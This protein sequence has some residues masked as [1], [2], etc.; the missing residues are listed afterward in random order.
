LRYSG[1]VFLTLLGLYILIGE[2]FS[3]HY[4]NLI[5]S[6][7]PVLSAKATDSLYLITIQDIRINIFTQ[8]VTVSGLR[9]QVDLDVLQRRRAEGRPPHVILD[10]SV[11][12]ANVSGVKWDDLSAEKTLSCRAVTFHQ[13]EIR[14]QIMPEWE[15]AKKSVVHRSPSISRVSAQK[16]TIDG[17]QLDVRYSYGDTGFSVQTRGGMIRASD[18]NYYPRHAFDPDR[19]FGAVAAEI[20]LTGATYSYP[21]SLYEYGMNSIAFNSITKEG[22]ISGLRIHPVLSHDAFYARVGFRKDV[23]ECFLPKVLVHDL[24]WRTLLT[25]HEFYAGD[26]TFVSPDFAIFYSKKPPV[27]PSRAQALYPSQILKH[28][29]LP[30]TV[31]L[32]NISDAAVRYSESN[33]KTGAT[34]TLEFDYMNGTILNVSNRD[35]EIA[36]SPVCRMLFNGKFM[37]RTSMGAII[38][39]PL[40][41]NKGAFSINAA[42]SDLDASQ[43][44]D[45]INALAIADLKSLQIPQASVHIVGNED[46]SW[47][48]FQIMYD[49]LKIKLLKWNPED[50]DVHSRVLLSFLAN[51]LLLYPSNPMQGES[52]RQVMSG[53]ARG[54][55]RSFFM[56]IWKNIFQACIRTAVRDDG[57]MD[58]VNRKKAN[59][60]KPKQPFFKDLF[61]KRK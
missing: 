34:G 57:A 61:P 27:A 60:G 28:S 37:H 55:T 43:I 56:M 10:V 40:Y 11:P 9:M 4:K 18:W 29:R 25:R 36:K 59:I 19:F 2:G 3:I 58:I 42:V 7:L 44:R 21:G 5:R 47:G 6:R 8:V 46:S 17:P 49:N 14:V 35:S 48:L 51:K 26:L 54:N 39:F 52:P 13:P 15:Q 16:I 12:E 41:S 20:S 22:A 53:I 45:Q 32:I 23:Y 31:P 1:I 50:S 24:D 33:N 38:D 30:I